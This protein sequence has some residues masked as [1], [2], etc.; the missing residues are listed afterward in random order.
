MTPETPIPDPTA[1]GPDPVA[2]DLPVTPSAPT[3]GTI[4][5]DFGTAGQITG[6]LLSGGVHHGSNGDE[7]DVQ[8]PIGDG[9]T[10]ITVP[11][12]FLVR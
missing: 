4:T 9:Y 12:Q 11:V 1:I 5:V 3:D 10:T 8:V 2:A 7:T 6:C